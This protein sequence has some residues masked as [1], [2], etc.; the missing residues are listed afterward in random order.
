MEPHDNIRSDGFKD[1]KK[2][3]YH[4]LS[5]WYWILI[6]LGIGLTTAYLINRYTTRVYSLSYSIVK[7]QGDQ[8]LFSNNV[9]YYPFWDRNMGDIQRQLRLIKSKSNIA[10]TL[11]GLDFNFS[12]F[13]QGNFKT[14]E[15]YLHR[16][17]LIKIDSASSNIPYNQFIKISF[18]EATLYRLQSGNSR[19]NS[20][21]KN[22]T[23]QLGEDYEMDGFKFSVQ[24]IK[25]GIPVKKGDDYFFILHNFNSLVDQFHGRLRIVADKESDNI[26]IG[27]IDS[28][29]QV[30]DLRFLKRFLEVLRKNNLTNK[31]REAQSSI[32]F[33]DSQLNIIT[34]TLGYY[35]R[36]ID[37][38][39]LK[40]L[41]TG[42]HSSN[43]TF[44]RI[45]FLEQEKSELLL[46]DNY[47]NYLSD[48]LK[49][50]SK[51]EIFAP[52]I[53]G[54]DHPLLNQWVMEYINLKKET[55]IYRNFENDKNPIIIYEGDE[56]GKI[57]RN[58][59][60]NIKNIKEN[61]Q[62]KTT[63]INNKINFYYSTL[64]GYQKDL[65][66]L[67]RVKQLSSINEE[68]IS[69]LL[70]RKIEINVRMAATG[71]DYEILDEPKVTGLIQ[72][73]KRKNLITATILSLMIPIGLLYLR[74][75]LNFK[76]Q[77]RDDLAV[78]QD[79]PFLGFIGHNSNK[80]EL[81]ITQNPKSA[82]A[83]SFRSVRTN[84]H[85]LT[86]SK[87]KG[88]F[89]I[90]SSISGEGKTFCAV[91]LAQVFAMSDK[92]TLLIAADLRK[93][94]VF[95]DFQ[96]KNVGGL[97]NYLSNSTSHKQIIQHTH[98]DNLDVILAG[99][100]PPNPTELMMSPQMDELVKDLKKEYDYIIFDTPPLGVVTDANILMRVADYSIYIVRQG[101]TPKVQLNAIK[102]S[103]DAGKL[104]NISVIFNDLGKNSK[105]YGYGYGSSYYTDEKPKK[106][107]FYR[108]LGR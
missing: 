62:D 15:I 72:P 14:S 65:R 88:V 42:D 5:N 32:E 11:N 63:E 106:N 21:V 56:L 95:K 83:E 8:D 103:Y 105:A 78:L 59:N 7:I 46:V 26:F 4:L 97:S 1:L 101:I 44:E 54:L 17:F 38:F 108:L 53:L 45:K 57:E 51:D 50:K 43:E 80:S 82:V 79:I 85:F 39:D 70:Q 10:E 92:K 60:E 91:N 100:I 107:I 102:E 33:I 94:K 16:P 47:L 27:N 74:M 76:V 52:V 84:I 13:L 35:K 9:V 6:S 20:L 37:E 61:N 34:D 86:G 93:P 104:K 28:E 12:V 29:T 81:V 23:F 75:L 99:P 30:K 69:L 49:K 90:T 58:I 31:N 36:L 89:L 48:Y 66:E 55:K 3:S 2:L 41:S 18:E 40:N 25:G 73:D 68:L 98:V 24:L 19:F 77:D 87:Q 22:K 96:L 64:K 67:Y 71:S